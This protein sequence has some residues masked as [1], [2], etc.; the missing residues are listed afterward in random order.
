[1]RISL[2]LLLRALSGFTANASLESSHEAL[3]IVPS[4]LYARAKGTIRKARQ[5]VAVLPPLS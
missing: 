4:S 3:G 5:K 2:L 1:M